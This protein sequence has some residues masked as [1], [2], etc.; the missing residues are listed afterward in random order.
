MRVLVISALLLTSASAQAGAPPLRFSVSDSWSMPLMQVGRDG[1]T[2]GI[3]FDIMESLSR[4][5][6]QTAEYR[7]YP[8]LRLQAALERG[9]VD[10]RCYAAQSWLPDMSGDYTWS[11]PL[12]NQRNV[13][14]S[15]SWNSGSVQLSDILGDHIGTVL[16]YSYPTLD[17][18][19][20]RGELIRE[21][22]RLQEQVLQKL[23]AHRFRYAVETQWSL[24][25]Y[26]RSRSDR[27]KLAVVGVI[28]EQPV[29]CIVRN[30]PDVPAQ[31]IMRTLLRMK[32]SGEIE[33][34]VD[35]YNT[36]SG[37]PAEPQ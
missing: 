4:Q 5:V 7:V 13:L 23:A 3:L 18:L 36:V 15:T 33:R 6:G 35:R 26:N 2:S 27:D 20:E 32:M 14:I 12:L 24:D 21:D 17:S 30:D 28:D 29:G 8:R 19:F 16:G 1:P 9:D 37:N 25:W 22:S 10:V 34:I 31:R 11:L